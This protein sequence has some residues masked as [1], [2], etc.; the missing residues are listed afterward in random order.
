[1]FCNKGYVFQVFGD[2]RSNQKV[3]AVTAHS[4]KDFV[5]CTR[6]PDTTISV[7]FSHTS[8][9]DDRND[10]LWTDP[11][12]ALLKPS[13]S[14]SSTM[15][16]QTTGSTFLIGV[17]TYTISGVTSYCNLHLP[18]WCHYLHHQWCHIILQPPPSSLVS[19]P[20]PS[21]VSHHTATSTFLIGV[22]IYTISGVTSYCNLHLPHWCH[23]LHHQWCHTILLPTNS[24]LLIAIK[25]F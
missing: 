3:S 14:P 19:L 5:H 6:H 20:T 23:Y 8:R 24:T 21:V 12:I 4:T 7:T 10:K 22:T 17:T 9:P 15:S 16:H 1:M 13:Q 11:G 18:H 25:V 2:R